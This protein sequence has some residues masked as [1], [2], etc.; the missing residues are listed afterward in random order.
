M[1]IERSAGR[2]RLTRLVFVV[3]GLVPCLLLA[4]WAVQRGS[5]AHRDAVR[6]AWQAAV[7]LQLDVAAITHPRPGVIA[8]TG[9]VVRSPAGQPLLE[10]PAV[11]VESAA[12][13][14]RLIVRGARIDAAAA[15]MLGSL[16]REWLRSDA[17]HPR[18]CVIEVADATWGGADVGEDRREGLRIECVGQGPAR[19]IRIVRGAGNDEIRAVRT[20]EGA[21]QSSAERFE[22]EGRLSRPLPVAVLAAVAGLPPEASAALASRAT[23]VGDLR[24][25][26]DTTGWSGS[27]SGRISTLDL[28]GCCAAVQANGAGAVDVSVTRFAWREGRLVDA[29]VVCDCGPGWID[30]ALF[31]RL[32]IALGCRP[33]PAF[34]ASAG[35]QAF[36]A[37]A[38][39][40]ELD[41]GKVVVRP[42]GIAN[43]LAASK[44]TLLLMPP[45][46]PVAFERFAWM[47]SPPAASFVPADGPGAWLMSIVPTPAIG[48]QR[49]TNPPEREGP[50]GF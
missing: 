40:L 6:A 43:G 37:A 16:A 19:A 15:S 4:G 7:G 29:A 44:G 24:A 11:E 30:A 45:A 47:V 50:R 31:D 1:F 46:A 10:L 22:V 33:G 25:V 3:A 48:P 36:D 41:G 28:G 20:L 34:Q 27:A 12:T 26:Y 49:A 5:A 13:E 38:C 32:V 2:I 9:V 18:N 8:A 23:T 14:D 42:G 21:G 17:R 39:L 35:T